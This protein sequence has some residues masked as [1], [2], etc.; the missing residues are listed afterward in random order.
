MCDTQHKNVLTFNA[1]NDDVLTD[2]EAAGA[3]AKL[4]SAGTP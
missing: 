1:V 4:F 3:D 2:S